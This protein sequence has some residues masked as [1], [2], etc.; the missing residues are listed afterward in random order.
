MKKEISGIVQQNPIIHENCCVYAIRKG[1]EVSLVLST[2]MQA[3]KDD[4]FVA[5][6][7]EIWIQGEA[8][9]V[10]DIKEIIFT[11][12]ASINIKKM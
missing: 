9:K 12:K 1:E 6:G 4:V 11:E 7:Q 3:Y 2:D 5:E 10:S 8:F